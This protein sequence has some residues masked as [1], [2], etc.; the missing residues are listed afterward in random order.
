MEPVK[1][2]DGNEK[3]NDS[4]AGSAVSHWHGYFLPIFHEY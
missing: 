3:Q 2:M 4:P 1:V